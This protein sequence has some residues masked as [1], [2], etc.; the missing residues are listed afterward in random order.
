MN[1]QAIGIFDSGLGGLTSVKEIKALLPHENVVYFGDTAR[2]PYGSK[3]IETINEFSEDIVSFL[4]RQKVKIVGIACNTISSVSLPALQS[5]FPGMTFV[6]IIQPM[7]DAL[8]SLIKN[9]A[10]VLVIGTEV[11]IASKMYEERIREKMPNVNVLAKA[12]PLFVNLIEQGLSD[13][14]IMDNVIHTY[15]DEIIT[16][17]NPDYIILGCTHYPLIAHKLSQYYPQVEML[18]PAFSQ[19]DA[20]QKTLHERNM[21]ASEEQV[22]QYHFYASDL[23]DI[24]QDMINNIMTGENANIAFN[25]LI[26]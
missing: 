11:T 25:E 18:N 8:P 3:S 10:T 20:L 24:F 22:A 12:C 9:D 16:E 15:L 7:V 2:T 1:N 21:E 4:M 19:A 23:S 6:D 26:L 5:K 13:E 17:K 14:P